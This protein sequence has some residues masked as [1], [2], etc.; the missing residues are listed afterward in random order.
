MDKVNLSAVREIFGK[1]VW[2]HKTHEKAAEICSCTNR[3]IKKINI[4]LLVLTTGNALGAIFQ[5]KPYLILTAILSTLSLLFLIYQL[6]FNPEQETVNHKKVAIRL[7]FIREKYQNFIADIMNEKI[8]TD[9]IVKKRDM[10]L[11][12][13]NRVLQDAPQTD[14]W[15]YK[16][17]KKALKIEEEMT[18]GVEEIDKFLPKELRLIK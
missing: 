12:E 4:I 15:A 10:L 5:I 8:S 13:L 2:T 1:V 9:E 18:F 3:Y 14:K 11:D 16:K 17:A 7:W 6:S